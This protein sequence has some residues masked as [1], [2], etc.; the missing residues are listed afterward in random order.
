MNPITEAEMNLLQLKKKG[1]ELKYLMSSQSRAM[2]IRTRIQLKY[3]K[4]KIDEAI[5]K[6]LSIDEISTKID[7]KFIP[8]KHHKT[9]F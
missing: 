7:T 4:K 9:Y 5:Q 6:S 8:Q 1:D 3:Y 2:K